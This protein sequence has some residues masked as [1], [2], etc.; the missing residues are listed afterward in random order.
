MPKA[1]PWN[2][3]DFSIF[4]FRLVIRLP[5]RRSG[6]CREFVAGVEGGVSLGDEQLAE[7][8]VLYVLGGFAVEIGGFC[9]HFFYCKL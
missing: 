8:E 7:G 6:L 3:F 5:P 4:K 2:N 9:W 1:F